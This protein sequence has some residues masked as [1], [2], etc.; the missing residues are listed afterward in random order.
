M[1][2]ALG[3]VSLSIFKNQSISRSKRK[4]KRRK[5]E[6]SAGRRGMGNRT[7]GFQASDD[8]WMDDTQ[9][10]SFFNFLSFFF[11]GGGFLDT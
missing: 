8:G 2:H 4:L 10:F 6:T 1:D 11:G 9:D 3:V 5:D 7:Q